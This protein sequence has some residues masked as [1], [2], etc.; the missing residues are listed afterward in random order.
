MGCKYLNQPKT[1]SLYRQIFAKVPAF[2]FLSSRAEQLC[3]DNLCVGQNDFHF[4]KRLGMLK[5]SGAKGK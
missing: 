1:C 5:A 3:K 4:Q 2:K